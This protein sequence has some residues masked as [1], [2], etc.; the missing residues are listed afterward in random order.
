MAHSIGKV[1]GDLGVGYNGDVAL[2]FLLAPHH[3]TNGFT[4]AAAEAGFLAWMRG[5]QDAAFA[6]RHDAS[7][8]VRADDIT[9]ACSE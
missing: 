5:V 7:I 4:Q 2:I 8:T 1:S 6:L 3:L 9:Q